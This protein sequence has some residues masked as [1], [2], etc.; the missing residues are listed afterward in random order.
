MRNEPKAGLTPQTILHVKVISNSP[1][2]QKG[3]EDAEEQK[4]DIIL[5]NH[6]MFKTKIKKKKSKALGK[7][8]LQ[9]K[10]YLFAELT[11][12]SGFCSDGVR[13]SFTART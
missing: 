6:K 7:V 8:N 4:D 2:K 9:K 11:G 13:R 5:I 10:T 1:A 3:D 12:L